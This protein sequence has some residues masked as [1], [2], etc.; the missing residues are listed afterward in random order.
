MATTEEVKVHF[1]DYWRI[2]RVRWPL[3]LLAFLLVFIT[4]SVVTPFST[5][6]VS[7]ADRTSFGRR[8]ALTGEG[9]LRAQAT[10]KAMPY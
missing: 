8:D 10:L 3:V 1:L 2:V 6:R 4:A 5:S 7:M 9:P